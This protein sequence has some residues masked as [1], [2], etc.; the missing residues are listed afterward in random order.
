MASKNFKFKEFACPCGVCNFIDG[1]QIDKDLVSKLQK[2]R[3]V[4]GPMKINS[5]LRCHT[6]NI[7]VGGSPKSYHLVGRAVDVAV[8]TS[9]DRHRLV[10][11]AVN[12]NLTVGIGDGFIH[13]DNREES[14]IFLY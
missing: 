7:Q 8:T 13:L 9:T 5:G 1:Y 4:Y 11:L 12:Q 6:R 2:I 10:K 3:D 14:I